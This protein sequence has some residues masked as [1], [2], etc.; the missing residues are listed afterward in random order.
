MVCSTVMLP[1]YARLT[2]G[3]TDRAQVA[4]RLLRCAKDMA[5]R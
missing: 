1:G 5:V 3:T 2:V 4:T